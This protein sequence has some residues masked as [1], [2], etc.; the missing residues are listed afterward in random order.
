MISGRTSVDRL[1]WGVYYDD[2]IKNCFREENIQTIN[3]ILKIGLWP[4]YRHRS[5]GQKTISVIKHGLNNLGFSIN[6]PRSVKCINLTPKEGVIHV[7]QP[8]DNKGKKS[9]GCPHCGGNLFITG[10]S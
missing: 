4:L 1:Y 9:V 10:S 5:M 3:D 6:D 7:S 8:Y 2:R